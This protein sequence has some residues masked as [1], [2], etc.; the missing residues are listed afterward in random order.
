MKRVNLRVWTASLAALLVTACSLGGQTYDDGSDEVTS[1]KPEPKAEPEPESGAEPE[2][3]AEPEPTAEPEP[4]AE[5]EPDPEGATCEELSQSASERSRNIA[6]NADR[7]CAVANDCVVVNVAP[8]CVDGCGR[9]VLMNTETAAAI[10][11]EVEAVGDAICQGFFASGCSV[12][13]VT[14]NPT[15]GVGYTCEAGQCEYV[16]SVRVVDCEELWTESMAAFSVEVELL[17]RTCE[18]HSDCTVELLEPRCGAPCGSAVLA[19]TTALEGG[20]DPQ[21]DAC[22]AIDQSNCPPP[23]VNCTTIDPVTEAHCNEGQCALGPPP[24]P[25]ECFAPEQNVDRAYEGTIPGCPCGDLGSVC[26]GGTALIC[27][28]D[29]RAVDDGPCEPGI[30]DQGC[31]GRVA[32]PQTCVELFDNCVDLDN[33]R[34]CGVGRRTELCD[35]GTLVEDRGDCL[36]DDA[37]C[38]E[39]ENGLYCT[40]GGSAPN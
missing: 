25:S 38:V 35:E 34:F 17:D 20:F 26:V 28:G 4:S 39:L 32:S 5:P 36:Q 31:D 33:G 10:T 19:N 22:L 23:D 11:E 9:E 3:S 18:V 40:G 13:P 15:G 16:D 27:Q 14:C 7:S 2:P 21:L 12:V 1:K 37:F 29:W 8:S 24:T 30:I 6:Q